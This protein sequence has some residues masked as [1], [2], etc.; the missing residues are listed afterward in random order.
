MFVEA[1]VGVVDVPAVGGVSAAG[2]AEPTHTEALKMA[3]ASRWLFVLALCKIVVSTPAVHLG[4]TI[5]TGSTLP[6]NPGLEFFG[7]YYLSLYDYIHTN[8]G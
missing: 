2:D 3:F 7:G 1:G 6:S 5:V 4:G 8:V